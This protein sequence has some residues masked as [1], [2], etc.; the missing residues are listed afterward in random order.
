MHSKFERGKGVF[1]CEVC[2]RKTRGGTGSNVRMCSQC[3]DVSGMEN[4]CQDEL[5]TWADA[6]QRALPLLRDCERKG[7]NGVR[8]RSVFAWVYEST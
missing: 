8:L 3:Y 4:E 5:V 2:E 6:R 1:S 7:G